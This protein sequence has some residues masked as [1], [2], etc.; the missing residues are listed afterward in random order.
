MI[1]Y[2]VV[3][4]L[5]NK[6]LAW[7]IKKSKNATKKRAGEKGFSNYCPAEKACIF[8]AIRYCEKCTGKS[9]SGKEK[10]KRVNCEN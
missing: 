7:L 2:R 6:L 5:R 9:N 8:S 1:G 4:L 10:Q 3:S